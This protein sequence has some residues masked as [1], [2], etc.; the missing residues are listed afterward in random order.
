MKQITIFIKTVTL[1]GFGVLFPLLIIVL[2]SIEIFELLVGLATPIA[3]L[4]PPDT[5]EGAKFPALIAVILLL[6]ASFLLGITAQT[7]LGRSIGRWLERNT[8]GRLPLYQALR[9]IA[10][11]FINA[12]NE[13]AF[14]PALLRMSDD[15]Y[16]LA[17]LIEDHGNG[18]STIMIPIA[19]TPFAGF[20]KIVPTEKLEVL[21]VGLGDVTRVLSQWGIGSKELLKKTKIS[22]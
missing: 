14:V 1:G 20:V 22:N 15:Q 3:S 12:E 21:D 18:R 19:P 7:N 2:M 17:Y 5:F 10:R 4:F 9:K 8:I 6:G 16:E 11:R 13:T